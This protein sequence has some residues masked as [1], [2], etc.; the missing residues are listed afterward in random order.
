MI[1]CSN[2]GGSGVS[3]LGIASRLDVLSTLVVSPGF[4]G[5]LVMGFLVVLGFSTVFTQFV[6]MVPKDLD[7]VAPILILLHSVRHDQLNI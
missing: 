7:V 1:L 3:T 5:G 2:L 6:Q 4:S